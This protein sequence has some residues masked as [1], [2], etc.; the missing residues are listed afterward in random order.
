MNFSHA[1]EEMKQGHKVRREGWGYH[2]SDIYIAI[3]N[4]IQPSEGVKVFN[5]TTEPYIYMYKEVDGVAPIFPT[6][7][8]CES[9]LADDWELA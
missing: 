4:P 9:I 6:P 2:G 8:S 5:P 1:L 3:Q 7:L